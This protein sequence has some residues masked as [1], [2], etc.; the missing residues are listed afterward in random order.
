MCLLQIVF[1]I[2]SNE[3][4]CGIYICF[5]PI[6]VVCAVHLARFVSSGVFAYY[7]LEVFRDRF[8]KR[9]EERSCYAV[10]FR[11]GRMSKFC[12]FF[13]PVFLPLFLYVFKITYNCIGYRER[14]A[15]KA[16]TFS[17]SFGSFTIGSLTT[18]L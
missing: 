16:G 12:A 8:G 9:G 7:N 1:I 10:W 11:S 13:L 5:W 6:S 14:S 15:T 18:S 4:V 3:K 17:L 2:W